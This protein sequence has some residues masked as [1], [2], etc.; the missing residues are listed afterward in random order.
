MEQSSSLRISLSPRCSRK[1]ATARASFGK[2][3]L[4]GTSMPSAN[5]APKKSRAESMMDKTL[6]DGPLDQGFDYY[7][8][9]G[10]INYCWIEGDRFVTIPTRPSSSQT[11]CGGRPSGQDRWP[12]VGIPTTSCHHHPKDRRVDFENEGPNPS[13]LTRLQFTALPDRSQQALSRKIESRLLRGLRH[14]DRRHGGQVMNALK[15]YGFAE[16]TLVVF[17]ADNG[18]SS[19]LSKDGNSSN[20]ARARSWRHAASRGGHRVPFI[21]KWPGKI[22]SGSVSDEVVSQVDLA[23]SFAKIIGHR[24]GKRLSTATIC[25]RSQG[26]EV[27][28]AP[29][30]RPLQN[31]SPKKFPS[32]KGLG[33]YQSRPA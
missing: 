3:H 22:N 4:G 31:T 29:A 9:D 20:G 21:V 11:P 32:V 17:T 16:N 15:K 13:S 24:L 10:T 18:P 2:W 33:L 19:M 6:P 5:R 26:R 27:R 30:W 8:G 12:K 14:R 7:F 23:A 25:C 28:Q 1:R